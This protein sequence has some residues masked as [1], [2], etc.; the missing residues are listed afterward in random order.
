MKQTDTKLRTINPTTEA[1]LNEYDIMTKEQINTK[2]KT[3]RTAFSEWRNDIDK[4]VDFLYSFA[5][6][7][8]KNLENLAR[9][10]TQE[11]GKAIKESRSE[12]EKCAWA[13]E[14]FADNGKIFASDEVV[15]TDARKSII[16][17]EPLGVIGSIMPWNFPYWQALRFAAPSLMVGNTIVLKP[18][19]ATMQCGIEIERTFNKSGLANGV[20]QTLIGDSSIA[21]TL[22]DSDINAVTFTGSVQVGGKVA[23][24]ATSQLKKTVLELGGSDPFIVCEDADMEKASS[25][26]VKGRFINSGQSCIASKRFIVVR[27]IANEFIEMF[28]QKTQKLKVGDP[29]SNETDIGPLVNINSLNNME[30]LVAQSVEEGAELLTGGERTDSKGFFYPPTVLKNVSPNMRI[31][32]EEVFGPIAPVII[33]EDEKEAMNVANDSKYGL[34]ASIWTQDLD[35]AERMSRAIESGIVTVNNVVISD[36]RVPFGGIK[37]SGFGRELSKYGML[38]F[39]NIK[40]VRFYDQLIH[41]HYVE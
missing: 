27:K 8:K 13:I 12:V 19:S 16:T 5:N 29:M 32:S 14:Y 24:R 17:F 23:Q 37:N 25:G 34:G 31:A 36:P 20:F 18:A 39:V 40:S 21:E 4:R 9:T 7:L 3:S 2:V 33:A 6:E 1:I 41:N 26:A 15:N 30:S 28:V 11:M 38:E 35:K 10:A 22:I